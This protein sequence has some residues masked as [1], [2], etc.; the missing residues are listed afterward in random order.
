MSGIL[1]TVYCLAYNHEDFKYKVLVHDDASNDKTPEIIKDYAKKYP[2]IIVPIFQNENQHSKGIKI[3]KNF[4][5]P[6]FEG[7]YIAICEGDDYWADE[8]KLQRQVS[9]LEK[10]DEYSACVHNTLQVN[11]LNGEESRIN[12]ST[13]EYDIAFEDVIQGGNRVFQLSSLV[14]RKEFADEFFLSDD[15]KFIEIAA[16]GD[17]PL[18][19]FL[20]LKG[21]I[22]YFPD[23]YSIYRI[24]T[25][26]SWTARHRSKEAMLDHVNNMNL[27]LSSVNE[28]TDFSYDKLISDIIKMNE[29]TYYFNTFNFH[30]LKFKYIR[31]WKDKRSFVY[32]LSHLILPENKFSFLYALYRNRLNNVGRK[33]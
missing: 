14:C 22:K 28:Y 13:V 18:S 29:F 1:V 8:R 17:Y 11:V 23:V 3:V 5:S 12:S 30:A 15:L 21:K 24:F 2:D 31:C 27:M 6:L 19:I 7:K 33:K 16:V 10:N 9:F 20:A 25:E 26:N 32:F 4:I